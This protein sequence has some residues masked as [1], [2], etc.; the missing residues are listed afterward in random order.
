MPTVNNRYL[1]IGIS[2]TSHLVC[3]SNDIP[4]QATEG[5]QRDVVENSCLLRNNSEKYK[6]ELIK[7]K[8]E[9]NLD[10]FE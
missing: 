9:E 6:I 5:S 1:T 3:T 2:A 8:Q 10:A 4:R 7:V